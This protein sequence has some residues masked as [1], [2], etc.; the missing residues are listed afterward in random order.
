[1]HESLWNLKCV[2]YASHQISNELNN[3]IKQDAKYQYYLMHE[4]VWLTAWLTDWLARRF[5]KTKTERKN[6]RKDLNNRIHVTHIDRKA[7]N[8]N[9]SRYIENV[10]VSEQQIEKDMK[11]DVMWCDIVA[12]HTT[13]TRFFSFIS[14]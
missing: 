11:C 2:A 13:K 14:N 10:K 6:Q 5:K 9:K 7:E 1:M 3:K 8:E 12:G 4:M